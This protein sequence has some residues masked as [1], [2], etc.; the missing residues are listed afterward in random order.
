M[1]LLELLCCR[2]RFVLGKRKP[3]YAAMGRLVRYPR[4]I[5][6][7]TVLCC[8]NLLQPSLRGLTK[9]TERIPGISSHP[10]WDRWWKMEKM[11]SAGWTSPQMCVFTT[12]YVFI[13]LHV[14]TKPGPNKL[15]FQCYTCGYILEV[16]ISV[17]ATITK[18]SDEM[19][20]R[21]HALSMLL[22][23]LP[24]LIRLSPRRYRYMACV[25]VCVRA[26]SG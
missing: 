12:L 7:G 19:R 10:G 6:R 22:S 2:R 15:I 14:T 26:S 11:E 24:N 1:K 17:V 20:Q 4:S 25:C 9:R 21:G 8:C 23:R 3:I 18:T 16:I 5:L 13:T